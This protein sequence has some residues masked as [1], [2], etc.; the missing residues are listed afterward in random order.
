VV[1]NQRGE[2][3][4]GDRSKDDVALKVNQMPGS[5]FEHVDVG[6]ELRPS[7]LMLTPKA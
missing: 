1:T 2:Q 6:H 7:H 5:D 3:V 4:R